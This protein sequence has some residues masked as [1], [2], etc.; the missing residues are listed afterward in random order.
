MPRGKIIGQEIRRLFHE[1][2]SNLTLEAMFAHG[3]GI[4]ETVLQTVEYETSH[5]R[6]L[7]GFYHVIE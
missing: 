1:Y 4:L 3:V 2:E 5:Q 6:D 7:S